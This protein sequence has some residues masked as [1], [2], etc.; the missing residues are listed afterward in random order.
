[1]T[2]ALDGGGV[3]RPA[4]VVAAPAG[5][6]APGPGGGRTRWVMAVMATV[7]FAVNFSAWA[8]LSP[9][10][11][12]FKDR[13]HLSALQ[14]ALVVAVPVVV[15]SVGR[16][17]VGALTDRFGARVT[18]GPDD[19]A[20]LRSPR[21]A[22]TV[23]VSARSSSSGERICRHTI[24]QGRAGGIGRRS[25]PPRPSGDL[26]RSRRALRGP[27]R[28]GAGRPRTAGQ[29]RRRRPGRR[30]SVCSARQY[31]SSPSHPFL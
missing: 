12:L 14:Q 24:T 29:P 30:R 13:L 17:P 5:S 22:E 10:G 28:A 27:S 15:G 31:A 18:D 1:M 6:T 19:Q 11:S 8:L 3:S 25:A 21:K 2:D 16:I 23:A 9:L 26:P 20:S 7:G 4:T